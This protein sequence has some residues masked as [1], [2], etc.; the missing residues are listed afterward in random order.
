MRH[1]SRHPKCLFRPRLGQVSWARTNNFDPYA[2]F[3]SVDQEVR[4]SPLATR[5]W[6]QIGDTSSDKRFGEARPK[7]L[8]V[9]AGKFGH[10]FVVC[11]PR[12]H[13]S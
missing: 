6:I 4:T 11:E 1:T 10:K 13:E 3:R 9:P 8:I 5:N 12:F 2:S 7:L